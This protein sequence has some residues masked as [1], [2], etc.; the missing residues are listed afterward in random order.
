MA[1]LIGQM[2]VYQK[3]KGK[4]DASCEDEIQSFHIFV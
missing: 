3:L 2:N 1:Y 4:R